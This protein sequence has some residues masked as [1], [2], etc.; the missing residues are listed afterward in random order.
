MK[1]DS[2]TKVAAGPG[3]VTLYSDTSLTDDAT[4]V[5]RFATTTTGAIVYGQTVAAG[6]ASERGGIIRYYNNANDRYVGIAG[7]ITQGTNYQIRLPDTIGAVGQVLAIASIDGSNAVMEWADNGSVDP[8]Q[9]K[10]D[11]MVPYGE[12]ASKNDGAVSIT[13]D[14]GT[15]DY[16]VQIE[17]NVS[18]VSFLIN[19]S[20][21]QTIFNFGTQ[22]G[23]SSN[24]NLIPG[25]WK[26]LGGDSSNPQKLFEPLNKTFVITEAP[27]PGC[28]ITTSSVTTSTSGPNEADGSVSITIS[29]GTPN[30][31]LTVT[32]TDGTQQ[33]VVGFVGSPVTIDDSLK[34]GTWTI[35]GTDNEPSGDEKCPITGSFVITDGAAGESF[36]A[37]GASPEADSAAPTADSD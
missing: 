21:N 19:G 29:N 9:L 2:G 26:V 10:V 24:T 31:N 36:F 15:P 32:H 7:P 18:G 14:G 1:T 22:A 5:A 8:N 16:D 30:Y 33:S 34:A 28:N 13:V 27:S 37:D 12:T 6:A 3:G 11:S 4:S 20:N 17:H 25:T 35:T 23:G